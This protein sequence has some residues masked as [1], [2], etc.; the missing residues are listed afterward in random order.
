MRPCPQWNTKFIDP[1]TDQNSTEWYRYFQ[2]LSSAA[3]VVA[4]GNADLVAGTVTVPTEEANG[5][6]EY[7]YSLT[8]RQVAGTQGL[9]R[10]S[11]IVNGQQF[12]INSSNAADT[13]RV[14]WV[15]YR[16]VTG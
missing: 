8:V 7:I 11:N 13:S 2:N 9:L 14:S 6:D 12:E 10:I 16:L 1:R 5:A 3:I 4:A 15:I